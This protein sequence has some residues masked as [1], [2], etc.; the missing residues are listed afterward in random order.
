MHAVQM[1]VML[2]ETHPWSGCFCPCTSRSKT[3]IR[4]LKKMLVRGES[5][6]P[7]PQQ[8]KKPGQSH[9]HARTYTREPTGPARTHR[10]TDRPTVRTD[11]RPAGCC[12]GM[13]K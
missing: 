6:S 1:Y 12:F 13:D 4:S 9:A 11:R 5:G 8:P 2:P 7:G 10:H 3:Q